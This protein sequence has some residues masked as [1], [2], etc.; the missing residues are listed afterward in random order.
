[1]AFWVLVGCSYSWKWLAAEGSGRLSSQLSCFLPSQ[2]AWGLGAAPGAGWVPWLHPQP[3]SFPLAGQG[4]RCLHLSF[5][6]G[7]WSLGKLS[8]RGKKALHVVFKMLDKDSQQAFPLLWSVS[9]GREKRKNPYKI[10]LALGMVKLHTWTCFTYSCV[11]VGQAT[12]W[13][14]DEIIRK[15]RTRTFLEAARFYET[16]KVYKWGETGKNLEYV[17]VG[18]CALYCVLACE[19]ACVRK[20]RNP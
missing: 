2:W 3:R 5:L 15:K 18:S 12:R 17:Y 13:T 7:W 8:G 14:A 16:I 11:S 1:M 20:T 4:P 19:R 9:G 10:R 6:E